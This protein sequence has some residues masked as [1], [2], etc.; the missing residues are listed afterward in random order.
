MGCY[1]DVP[2]VHLKGVRHGRRAACYLLLITPASSLNWVVAGSG[3]FTLKKLERSK[4]VYQS[5]PSN[6]LAW[7]NIT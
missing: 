1:K 3:L 5:L 7:D 4:R 2:S 6:I